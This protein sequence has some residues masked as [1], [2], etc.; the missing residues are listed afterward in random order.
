M[1][2]MSPSVRGVQSAGGSSRFTETDPHFQLSVTVAQFAEMLRLS[3][4]IRISYRDLAERARR[5][6]TALPE[7]NQV[8]E[9]AELVDQAS[10]IR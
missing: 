10:R 5:I 3:P 8:Y 7:D 6:A 4:Y 9:F 2:A 1:A